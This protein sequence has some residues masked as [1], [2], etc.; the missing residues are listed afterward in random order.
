MCRDDTAADKQDAS[1]SSVTMAHYTVHFLLLLTT[2]II[3]I[4]LPYYYHFHYHNL[5]CRGPIFKRS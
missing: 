3:S 2:I 4:S 5:H 1:A